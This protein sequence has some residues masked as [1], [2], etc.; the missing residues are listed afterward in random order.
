ML[1]INYQ[2]LSPDE[3]PQVNAD[4]P[5]QEPEKINKQIFF[6]SFFL[7]KGIELFMDIKENR[8]TLRIRQKKKTKKKK[9]YKN[10]NPNKSKINHERKISQY[11]QKT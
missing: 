1:L 5:K 9:H 8:L 11:K 4:T 3:L 10:H 6:F 2:A 7:L